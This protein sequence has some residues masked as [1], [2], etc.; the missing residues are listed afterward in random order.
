MT[1]YD[2]TNISGP[3][4]RKN[5]ITMGKDDTSDLMITWAMDISVQSSKLK[6]ASWTHNIHGKLSIFY[7]WGHIDGLVQDCS[8]SIVKTLELLLSGTKPLICRKLF[9]W[10]LHSI[11]SLYH[12]YYNHIFSFTSC[13][14]RATARHTPEGTNNEANSTILTEI[15]R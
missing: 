10:N 8:N 5:M 7:D 15:M 2:V 6:W 1:E 13:L 9:C 12:K 3:Q 4:P 11:P 14:F